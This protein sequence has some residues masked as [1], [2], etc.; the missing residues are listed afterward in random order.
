MCAPTWTKH[1][2]AYLNFLGKGVD[3]FSKNFIEGTSLQVSKCQPEFYN[4]NQKIVVQVEKTMNIILGTSR[5]Q[6]FLAV[7]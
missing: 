4:Y 3:Q 7:S 2:I 5:V 1:W 6:N